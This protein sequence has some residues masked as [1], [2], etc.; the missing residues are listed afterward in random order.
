MEY[1]A[2]ESNYQGMIMEYLVGDMVGDKKALAEYLGIKKSQVLKVVRAFQDSENIDEI[3]C[4]LKK[5]NEKQKIA[6]VQPDFKNLCEQMKSDGTVT[7]KELYQ[8]YQRTNNK[9]DTQLYKYDR[10]RNLYRE[11]RRNTTDTER[12]DIS[13]SVNNRKSRMQY[14]QPNFENLRSRVPEYERG[15]IRALYKKYQKL[16]EENKKE[17][18]QYDNFRK[19]YLKWVEGNNVEKKYHR[20]DCLEYLIVEPRICSYELVCRKAE[21]AAIIPH[22]NINGFSINEIKQIMNDEK[23]SIMQ[24][25]LQNDLEN[26]LNLNLT[27]IK[28]ELTNS[29]EAFVLCIAKNEGKEILQAK[30]GKIEE[31]LRNISF[32]F[33]IDSMYYVMIC[34]FQYCLKSKEFV[35]EIE[36]REFMLKFLSLFGLNDEKGNLE[37]LFADLIKKSYKIEIPGT[38]SPKE[39]LDDTIKNIQRCIPTKILKRERSVKKISDKE[40]EDNEEE[41]IDYRWNKFIYDTMAKNIAP[42][43]L[44]DQ[45]LSSYNIK[46]NINS[47]I[48][49][50][51]I[52]TEKISDS[53]DSIEKMTERAYIE[54]DKQEIRLIPASIDDLL[55]EEDEVVKKNIRENYAAIID[56]LPNTVEEIKK[57]IKDDLQKFIEKLK[58]Y[59]RIEQNEKKDGDI[60]KDYQELRTAFKNKMKMQYNDWKERTVVKKFLNDNWSEFS[61]WIK[62]KHYSWIK[63]RQ[64]L[65][66][67]VAEKNV[68]RDSDEYVESY[69]I[70]NIGDLFLAELLHVKKKN[71]TIHICPECGMFYFEEEKH[72]SKCV[73]NA[74]VREIKTWYEERKMALYKQKRRSKFERSE[75]EEMYEYAINLYKKIYQYAI[76]EYRYKSVDEFRNRI[77][78]KSKQENRTSR[79]FDGIPDLYQAPLVEEQE[80]LNAWYCLTS[81]EEVSREGEKEIEDM[82]NGNCQGSYQ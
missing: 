8:L 28:Q 71:L 5:Q 46:K 30:I 1:K 17:A 2:S 42:E 58:E 38:W 67:M 41:K 64:R 69:V 77:K 66:K 19:R 21:E 53:I 39:K 18:Y 11:W 6:Y 51:V 57:F 65:D 44:A 68:Y 33:Q 48:I 60:E 43:Y 73:P 34:V 78:R 16:C 31:I 4:E 54:F 59:K 72:K 61:K 40:E 9:K 50:N 22:I 62:E 70:N 14:E 81:N 56:D 26:F 37:E 82:V 45:S 79:N 74:T 76:I 25:D 47:T 35:Q 24:F 20:K 80:I 12:E 32:F 7:I 55:Y 27:E 52:K 29:I 13:N 23:M 3:V 75:V 36:K 49:E 10:F 15:K 63:V